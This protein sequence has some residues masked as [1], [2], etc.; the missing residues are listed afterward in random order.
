MRRPLLIT[1]LLSASVTVAAAAQPPQAPAE[2]SGQA[3]RPVARPVDLTVLERVDALV[4]EAIAAK[5][6]PG[7]VLL[8][9]RGPEVLYQKAYGHRA[10]QP[11]PEP[12]TLDTIFDMASVTK[13]VATTTSVMILVE[14]GR[15]RLTD[16]VAAYIPDFGRYGKGGITIRHL[17]THVS[18]LRPDVDLGDP[19]VG[20]D[21]AIALA[22]EEVPT[23]A[24]GERF[25][26]SDINF[27]LLAD[28]VARVSGMPFDVFAR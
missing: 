19:W 17:L 21:K 13:T 1:L 18:G 5:Q 2:S 24:P 11:S 7:A 3:A 15:L 9:G 22:A 4:A 10:L 12:M 28:I 23:S 26:Y 27:F 25:V 6:M 20:Y 8:V 14:E 16:R